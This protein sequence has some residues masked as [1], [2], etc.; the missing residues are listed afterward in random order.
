M[1][2][3]LFVFNNEFGNRDYAISLIK[4]IP[5]VKRWR[6]DL[7]NVIYIKS[8]DSPQKLCDDV[9]AIRNTGKF[10]IAELTDNRQGYLSKETWNFFKADIE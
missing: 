7:P 5:A 9:R 4:Q 6:S 2:T 1:K 10:L 3:Y 8:D